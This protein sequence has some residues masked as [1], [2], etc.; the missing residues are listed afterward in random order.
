MG[1]K[2][3]LLVGAKRC[4]FERGYAR[5]TARDIVAASGTNLASIGYHFGSKDALLNAALIQALGEWADELQRVL[6]ADAE[7]GP[8]RSFEGSWTRVI[9]SFER[10]RQLIVASFEALVQ[11][12][13]NPQLNEQRAIANEL[14]RFGLAAL[15]QG[16][17]PGAADEQTV[18]AV[19]SFNLALL[20]GLMSQWLIDPKRAPSGRDLAD[21]LR[22][23][24]GR[25]Q[26]EADSAGAR[27]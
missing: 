25:V 14:A 6:S 4:L 3:Q 15:F 18:R 19:G 22:V 8:P 10:N 1:H 21:A 26:S 23:I 2:A 12:I 27:G 16:I 20:G 17:E 11:A 24:A 13:H 5:T 9:E 7:G